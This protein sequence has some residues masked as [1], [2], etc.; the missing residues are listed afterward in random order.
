[1]RGQNISLLQTIAGLLLENSSPCVKNLNLTEDYLT[2]W[3]INVQT[4][5]NDQGTNA[6]K[7]ISEVYA[8][9]VLHCTVYGRK[10]KH[11]TDITVWHGMDFHKKFTIKY[12]G[13]KKLLC[14]FLNL[15]KLNAFILLGY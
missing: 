4:D 13:H 9:F 12:S 10:S 7:V 15:S 2:Y 11:K 6:R 1:M 8:F 3:T 14:E 5:R